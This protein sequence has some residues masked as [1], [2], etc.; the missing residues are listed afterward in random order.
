MIICLCPYLEKNET[1]NLR[2]SQP[3]AFRISRLLRRDL[4]SRLV[5]LS[6]TLGG[7]LDSR[8]GARMRKLA[9]CIV[10][11]EFLFS[12]SA[13][14]RVK[15]LA[16]RCRLDTS[17]TCGR[18]RAKVTRCD[19]LRFAWIGGSFFTKCIQSK[20]GIYSKYT[21]RIKID[22]TVNTPESV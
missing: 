17:P 4:S 8:F 3:I 18:T 1:A 19:W 21:H 20:A 2:E 14:A 9:V 11:D 13:E 6:Q 16:E 15:H 12:A 7:M 22:N 5:L 10:T